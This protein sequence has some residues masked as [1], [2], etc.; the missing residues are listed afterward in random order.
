VFQLVPQRFSKEIGVMTGVVGA[1]GGI[2]GFFLP[3]LFGTMK[4]LTGTYG[5]GF[6]V[7]AGVSLLCVG[8]LWRLRARWESTFL[9]P[10]LPPTE[11]VET[12]VGSAAVA[13]H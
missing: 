11:P 12:S 6:A 4:R 2:G 9:A 5:T 8:L 7:F 13:S 10:T 3:N 1:A